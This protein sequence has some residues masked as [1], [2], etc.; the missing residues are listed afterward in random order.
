MSTLQGKLAKACQ[1]TW[2]NNMVANRY[3]PVIVN[4][5]EDTTNVLITGVLT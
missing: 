3:K 1:N 5:V 2:K 4:Q